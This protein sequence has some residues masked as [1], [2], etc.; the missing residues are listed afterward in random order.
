MAVVPPN[1]NR[2]AESLANRAGQILNSKEFSPQAD[3]GDFAAYPNAIGSFTKGLAHNPITGEVDGPQFQS[4]ITAL[5]TTDPAARFAAFDGLPDATHRKFVNPTAGHAYETEGFDPQQLCIAPAP[6]LASAEEAFEAVENYWMALLRDVPFENYEGETMVGMASEELD[7]LH[8]A[9]LSTDSNKNPRVGT[10]G[11]SVTAASLFRGLTAGDLAGPYISQ[12]M[13]LPVPFGAQ[14]WHQL[15]T[16]PRSNIDFV[17]RWEEFVQVQNGEL[18]KF[19]SSEFDPRT[20]YIRNGRDLSQWVHIDVLFQAYFNACLIMLQPPDHPTPVGGGIGVPLS[21]GNP[22]RT[23]RRQ[24][25]FG[26]L[27]DPGILGLMCEASTRAL[28]AVWYQKW[29]VHMRLR[30]EAFGGW[31]HRNYTTTTAAKPY[32]IHSSMMGS[33]AVER[34]VVKYGS[35]LLPQAFPEGSPIHPAYGAGHATVAG[36]CVTILK[37]LF[38]TSGV[39]PNPRRIVTDADG[40]SRWVPYTGGPLTIEGE[41][42]KLASN[43]AIGRNIAGVHWRSDATESLR[44]GENVAIGLLWDYVRTTPEDARFEFKSFF[45]NPDGTPRLI[46]IDKN[47]TTPPIA[48][49]HLPASMVEAKLEPAAKPVTAAAK[50]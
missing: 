10:I 19:G 37:A 4:F 47:T 35:A 39:I 34:T 42:N 31:V 3:N 13:L 33:I 8:K 9:L 1:P 6:T 26:I 12:F 38:D 49:P 5:Q 36:A 27:G 24:A 18:R 44:L 45:N 16:T 20:T 28:K 2:K 17:T 50:R 11:G 30:P 43:V 40:A 15:M 25:G 14:G 23:S 29:S 21:T 46:V 48:E 32:P 22:F 41:L 7:R